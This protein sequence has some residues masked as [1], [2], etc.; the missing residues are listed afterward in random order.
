MCAH[1][2]GAPRQAAGFPGHEGLRL[3]LRAGFSSDRW[4]LAGEAGIFLDPFYSPGLDLIA[5]SNGLIT[6]LITR[7][8]EG[9]DIDELAA[10]HNTVFFLLTD[11]WLSIYEK[12]YP[13]MG[14]A[15]VM[16]SKVIWDTAVYWAVPGLLYFHDK[17]RH[18]ADLPDVL[19]N[20]ASFS[21]TS[22]EVQRFFREW[23]AVDNEARDQAPFVRFYDFDFM[24]RL[25][26]GMTAALS[27]T[28]LQK[29]FEANVRFIDQLSGQMVATLL[30]EFEAEPD[31]VAKQQQAQKWRADNVLMSLVGVYEAEQ[32]A[33]PISD[34]WITLRPPADVS[35]GERR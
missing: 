26:V 13:L 4:C 17:W 33:N 25:H 9:E 3:Q 15:R 24:P 22:K 8:L 27:D 23:G 18:L 16:L 32:Q 10:I 21:V 34:G 11:G 7:A 31:N 28:E 19:A 2:R 29:Q 14:N 1:H 5:I 6:D 30:A 20:L 35:T 12:Q